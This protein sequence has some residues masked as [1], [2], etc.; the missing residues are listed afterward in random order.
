MSAALAAARASGLLPAG[1]PVLVL[2]SGGRDSVCLLDCA[3]ELGALARALYVDHGLRDESEAGFCGQLCE[4]LGVPLVVERLDG[5][6]HGNVQAW[7]R[8]ARYAAAER[9]ATAGEAIAT[10]HTASDQ[11]EGVLYRLAAAP[12]RRALRGMDARSGRRVRPL[13]AATRADT[14]AHCR[15]RGLPWRDD[16]TNAGDLYARGRVRHGL[17][18]ALRSLHPA[19]EA[20]V[21]R[22]L[23]VLRDEAEVLDALVARSR[24]TPL[25]E[26][27]PAL[28]RLVLQDLADAAAGGRAPAVGARL[29]AVLALGDRGTRRL[30][31]GGG[32][33]AVSEYGRVRVE[34]AGAGAGAPPAP[35]RLPVPGEARFGAWT[36]R[37]GPGDEEPLLVRAPRPGDRIRR[38][39]GS[40]SLQDLFVDAK[41]PRAERAGRPVVCSGDGEVVWVPGLALAD[42]PP[43]APLSAERY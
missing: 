25:N 26:L 21:L 5:R 36:L 31:L 3:R 33:H 38:R 4:R 11:V 40:R 2:L 10:G 42:P 16:P 18:P 24:T 17:L 7:A 30:D 39:G 15:A 43:R 28:A 22:T 1:G 27:P 34:R 32:L 19:A 9:V 13:L 23:A 41:V 29:D 6:P 35:V 12:G 20:N 14:E 8:A 37:A